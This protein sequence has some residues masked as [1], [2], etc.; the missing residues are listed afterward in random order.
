[1]GVGAANFCCENTEKEMEMWKTGILAVAFVTMFLS[2]SAWAAQ[3][4]V[5]ELKE[6]TVRKVYV[7]KAFVGA[8][9]YAVAD[10]AKGQV[11]VEVKNFPPAEAG[12]EVFLFQ[13]DVKAYISAMFVDGDPHKGIVPNPPPFSA[14]GKMIKKWKSLGDLKMD[15]KGNGRLEYRKG[16]NLYAEDLNMMMVF[17][18]KTPG[19]H[20][21]PEDFSKLMVECNGPLVGAKGMGEMVKAM[22]IF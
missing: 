8:K 14:V 17:G 7:K 12:Y 5:T 10:W 1:M 19:Q 2:T 22:R 20:K 18:K 21:G 11:R 15:A 6:G 16:D 4:G 13:I 3:R 9:G